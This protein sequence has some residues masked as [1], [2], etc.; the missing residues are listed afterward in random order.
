MTY[1]WGPI[2]TQ[3]IRDRIFLPFDT[4]ISRN[5]FLNPSY[6]DFGSQMN[7]SINRET[8]DLKQDMVTLNNV[9]GSKGGF[10]YEYFYS[11]IIVPL[12]ELESV[13][14]EAIEYQLKEKKERKLK[15]KI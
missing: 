9:D 7:F 8:L 6:G 13:K 15:Q 1:E 11:C 10:F 14:K 5:K 3:H 4:R 12:N 2:F